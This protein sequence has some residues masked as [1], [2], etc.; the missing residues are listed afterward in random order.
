MIVNIKI[1]IIKKNVFSF[2]ENNIIIKKKSSD[3]I[4]P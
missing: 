2:A 1:Y 4:A 3:D